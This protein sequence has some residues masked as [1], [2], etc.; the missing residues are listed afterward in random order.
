VSLAADRAE[1]VAPIANMLEAALADGAAAATDS[2]TDERAAVER[3]HED[4]R[5]APVPPSPDL[6]VI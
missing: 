1:L 3:A 5:I 6:P 2:G 4:H